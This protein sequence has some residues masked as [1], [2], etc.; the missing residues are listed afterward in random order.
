MLLQV[1]VAGPEHQ[2]DGVESGGGGEAA[3]SRQ[4]HA[5]PVANHRPHRGPHGRSVPR[6][7]R[8]PPVRCG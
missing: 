7:L 3:P 8:V 2:E 4:A 6:T 5:H 1:R